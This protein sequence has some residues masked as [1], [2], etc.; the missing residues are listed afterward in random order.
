MQSFGRKTGAKGPLRRLRRKI[1]GNRMGDV[2]WVCLLRV[3]NSDGAF[4]NTVMNFPFP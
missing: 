3:G 1:I 4:A 2:D